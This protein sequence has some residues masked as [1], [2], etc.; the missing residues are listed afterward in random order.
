[1]WMSKLPKTLK[2]SKLLLCGTHH[3]ASSN[4]TLPHIYKLPVV[5][6]YWKSVSE[7]QG[8]SVSSQLRMGI[9]YLHFDIEF[10]KNEWYAVNNFP[11]DKFSNILQDIQYFVN[12]YPN[13]IVFLHIK[14][15]NNI[16][17][18]KC[19]DIL[20]EYL[21]Y[22]LHPGGKTW[23]DCTIGSLTNKGYNV[24]V[25]CNDAECAFPYNTID[26]KWPKTW[27]LSVAKRF[28]YYRLEKFRNSNPKRDKLYAVATWLTPPEGFYKKYALHSNDNTSI[29]DTSNLI[30]NYLFH[31]ITCGESFKNMNIVIL[32]FAT[33]SCVPDKIIELCI[34]RAKNH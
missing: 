23:Q 25:F 2:I 11:L 29:A 26:I 5:S 9:R 13:E 4:I 34:E 33:R 28:I 16:K 10:L 7:C 31:H 3:S 18:K 15:V 20:K 1:M 12:G 17:H 14:I 21:K 19:D 27:E 32:D 24:I 8:D 22:N 6:D 30:N